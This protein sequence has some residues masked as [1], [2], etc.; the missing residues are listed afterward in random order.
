MS[1]SPEKDD[2]KQPRWRR[3]KED[4]P[5]ELIAAATDIFIERGYS[6]TKLDDIAEQ[7][8][9]TKGTMYLYFASKEALFRE[10]VRQGVVDP[11]LAAQALVEAEE[12]AAAQTLMNLMRNYVRLLTDSKASGIIKLAMSEANNFPDVAEYYLENAVYRARGIFRHVLAAGIESGE[13]RP[14]NLDHVT[15]LALAP[16]VYGFVWQHSLLKYE[17][18][19][20]EPHDYLESHI[21]IFLRGVLKDP[22]QTP[23]AAK[24]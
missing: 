23:G 14:V 9:V 13:F 12:G 6:A 3:R 11:L 15:R 20:S 16:M 2:E 8:G 1:E 18:G 17:K 4:R 7:A 19:K 24:T 21:D 5:A 10:V 22:A